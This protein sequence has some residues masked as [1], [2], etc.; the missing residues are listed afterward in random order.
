MFI[1]ARLAILDLKIGF[2]MRFI[3]I[4]SFNVKS[5]R[6]VFYMVQL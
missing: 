1:K 4:L 2:S 3:Y 5:L 6:M